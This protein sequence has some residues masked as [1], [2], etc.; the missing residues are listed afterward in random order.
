M[1]RNTL[2]VPPARFGEDVADMER[3]PPY[4]SLLLKVSIAPNR[5]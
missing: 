5:V 1:I 2:V 3:Y 4:G